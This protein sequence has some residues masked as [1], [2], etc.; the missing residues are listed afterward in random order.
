MAPRRRPD[1]AAGVDTWLVTATHERS[2][3]AY[4]SL[5]SMAQKLPRQ[6]RVPAP[7]V[8]SV[9]LMGRPDAEPAGSAPPPSTTAAADPAAITGARPIGM[10][11]RDKETSDT[12]AVPILGRVDLEAEIAR[13]PPEATAT[14][15]RAETLVQSDRLRVVLVTM[16]SG[17]VLREHAAPGPITIQALRGRFAVTV[18]DEEHEL[19]PGGLLAIEMYARHTVDALDDGAFL[20]TICWPTGLAGD[21]ILGVESA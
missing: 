20:L 19:G 15:R 14:R 21:P 7:L 17:A 13:F 2:G 16:L 1:R 8:G 18:G 3:V 4:R 6:A 12:M 9:A 10:R 5:G 11:A